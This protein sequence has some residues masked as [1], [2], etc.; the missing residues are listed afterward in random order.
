MAKSGLEEF[1]EVITDVRSLTAWAVGGAVAAPLFDFVLHLG[2]P[3]PPGVPVITSLVEL[4]SLICI[5]HF[6]FRKT[7]KKLTGRMVVAL[8]VL[9]LSL[10][11][12]LYLFGSY[13]FVNPATSKRYAKGFTVRP[14]IQALIPEQFDSPEK[15]LSGSEYREEEVW[16]AG[17]IMAARL[18]LLAAWLIMFSS[19]SVF[20]G[21]F[22]MAQRRK[23]V[24]GRARDGAPSPAT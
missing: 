14:E 2:A 16:T 6:W 15:A 9:L 24:R 5:F 1:R 10:F 20:I 8:I 13:T 12:Y 22:V 17:S 11:C 7:Q 4:I 3:W 19:L 21:T 18:S 23:V